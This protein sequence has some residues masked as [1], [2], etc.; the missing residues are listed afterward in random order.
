M[1]KYAIEKYRSR[2]VSCVHIET[3]TDDAGSRIDGLTDREA[4]RKRLQN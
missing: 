3:R 1:T 2:E 4:D